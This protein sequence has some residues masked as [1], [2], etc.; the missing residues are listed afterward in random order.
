MPASRGQI[1]RGL[2]AQGLRKPQA[3]P[4]FGREPSVEFCDS[5]RCAKNLID[6][7]SSQALDVLTTVGWTQRLPGLCWVH[8]HRADLLGQAIS[9]VIAK[10]IGLRW[11][12]LKKQRSLFVHKRQIRA[13]RMAA[14]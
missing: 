14:E 12:G 9:L 8:L 10:Q 4:N 6:D 3:T 11:P 13:G 5:L 2:P 1:C 7:C